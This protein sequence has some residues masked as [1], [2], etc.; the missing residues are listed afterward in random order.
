MSKAESSSAK[1]SSGEQRGGA[2]FHRIQTGYNKDNT[3]AY[4]YFRSKEE[5]DAYNKHQS[6]VPESDKKNKKEDKKEKEPLEDKVDTEHKKGAKK[7]ESLFI[8]QKD[9]K[10]AV[11]KGLYLKV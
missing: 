5:W 2:Y 7:T 4:R 9:V 11:E 1:I 6:K 3:P 10:G 8:K